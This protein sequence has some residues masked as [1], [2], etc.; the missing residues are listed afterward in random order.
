MATEKDNVHKDHRKR[1]RAEAL[2]SFDS[3]NDVSLLE[4]LLFYV[5]PRKD[6]NELAHELLNAFGSIAGVLDA[7]VHELTKFKGI[8]ENGALLL[9][10]IMPI[11]ARYG[12]NKYKEG[13]KFKNVDE[14]GDF[15]MGKYLH[16]KNETFGVLCLDGVGKLKAF[17][18][19]SEGTAAM[20]GVTFREIAS[21]VFKYN[22]PCVI[23]VHNHF[24]TAVP[25]D[26]DI[27]MTISLKASL[28]N[29]GTNLLDHII[30]SGDDYVSMR[31]SAEFAS[32]FK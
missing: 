30:V 7:E 14:I 12:D 21:V 19:L 29:L 9:K 20:V 1:M 24:E 3:F 25:S 11:A 28:A 16:L 2:K 17:E 5:I 32:I 23:I 31:Q 8:T 18:L 15:L 13:Y 22:A 4:F 10:A 27:E 26:E 6:T